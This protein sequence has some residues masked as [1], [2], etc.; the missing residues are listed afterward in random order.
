MTY[1]EKVDKILEQRASAL[2]VKRGALESEIQL[3][4][5]RDFN[6]EYLF[7]RGSSE[8]V[9]NFFETYYRELSI[10]LG[11][12]TTAPALQGGVGS[13]ESSYKSRFSTAVDLN[14]DTINGFYPP[15]SFGIGSQN[16]NTSSTW[17]TTNGD[18]GET[19][20]GISG[21]LNSMSSAI[22]DLITKR[23][24][25]L[26]P[27]TP[28]PPGDGNPDN[29]DYYQDPEAAVLENSLLSIINGLNSYK[30]YLEITKSILQ[31]VLDGNNALCEETTD[32]KT[33]IPTG[34]ISNINSFQTVLQGHIDSVQVEYNYFSAL[35]AG[36]SRGVVDTKLNT[37]LPNLKSSIK[38]SLLSR[39]TEVKSAISYGDT[40]S[41]IR[42]WLFFWISQNI[43]KPISP[44][45]GLNGISQSIASAQKT[46]NQSN[47]A[48]DILFG[49]TGKYIAQPT[50]IA[51]FF[52]PVLDEEGLV[53][54][55]KIRYLW[56]GSTVVNKYKIFKQIITSQTPD[57]TDWTD[58]DL[59]TWVVTKNPDTSS[60]FIEYV[61]TVVDEETGYIYRVQSFDTNEGPTGD[62][63]RV[64]SFNTSSVQSKIYEESG[65]NILG[66][67]EGLITTDIEHD[68]D[69]NTY[70]AITGT[71]SN[72]GYYWVTDVTPTTIQL[73]NIILSGG[74][75]GT[76]HKTFGTTRYSLPT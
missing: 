76:V 28:D 30:N 45:V 12:Q 24:E 44:Y 4:E 71:S 2:S 33:D 73:E 41:G 15:D 36:Y 18:N 5:E 61:D 7:G 63:P 25:D 31:K 51:A 38:N 14:G 52:D 72:D 40:S 39:E 32:L 69:E 57:N 16:L 53:T 13:S 21:S 35:P 19:E 58:S 3:E 74:E 66:I 47:E 20:G 60:I 6:N 67:N 43:Q 10:G 65:I 70:I 75:E 49:D 68:I 22:S 9:V 27:L 37:T 62:I 46:L 29:P 34:D 26:L 23:T 1:E 64:D 48:L 55:S 11:R 54:Q 56:L 59:L 17:F 42:K 8:G 50:S